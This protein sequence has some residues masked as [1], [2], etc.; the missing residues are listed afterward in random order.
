MKFQSNWHKKSDTE[1]GTVEERKVDPTQLTN[2]SGMNKVILVSPVEGQ[3]EHIT[4]SG[5]NHIP[6]HKT[7]P[8]RIKNYYNF[9]Y[10]GFLPDFSVVEQLLKSCVK[11]SYTVAL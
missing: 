4:K 8:R 1:Y 11:K 6:L 5:S 2:G 10:Y 7:L 9:C 3:T